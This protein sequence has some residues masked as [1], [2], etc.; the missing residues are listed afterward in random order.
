MIFISQFV[1]VIYHIYRFVDTVPSLHPWDKSY[2][3]MV[4]DLSDILL[5]QI[6]QNF[7]E[8]FDIYVHEGYWP[9]ILFHCVR[10]MLASQKKVGS[11]PFS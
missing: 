3:V 5:D 6:C 1:Y 2:L 11:V 8:D 4:Y 10:V 9:V 7:F